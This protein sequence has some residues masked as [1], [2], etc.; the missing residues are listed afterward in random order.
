MPSYRFGCSGWDYEEWIGPFYRSSQQSK[1]AAYSAVFNT[2]EIN[3][4]FYRAPTKGMVIGWLRYS[5][6]DFQFAAKVPQTVTH[7]KLLA[8]TAE[9]EVREF[10]D[11]M[12]PLLDAGKLGPLL[13][14]LP[15]RLRFSEKVLRPFFSLLPPEFPWA[16]EPRNKTWMVPEA[17]DLLRESHVAYTIVDEPLLPPEV[18]VTADFAYLRWHGHGQDPWYDYHYS[19]EELS[20]W[21][22][23]VQEAAS[24]SKTAYGFFNN[25]FHGYAP[26]NCLQIL[27]MLGQITPTQ[28]KAKR[29]IEDWRQGVS[30]AGDVRTKATTLEDF[31]AGKPALRVEE[32]LAKM[33]DRGRLERGKQIEAE[34]VEI[35]LESEEV[36]ARVKEYRVEV[37]GSGRRL[38]HDCDDFAKQVEQRGLCKHVVRAFLSMPPETAVKV[39]G[40][41]REHRLEWTFATPD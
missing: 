32:L 27:E 39:L 11:L 12:R 15:P 37:S 16:V 18:H 7:E 31:A 2:A 41:L 1:L 6:A 10:C 17:F 34:E 20:G 33:V 14:Q 19:T 5:P 8:V 23:K 30:R 24:K 36:H 25:H 3:S 4:S 29:T 13:L 40:D 26:E 28:A 22:P 35:E 21:V 9:N 38:L